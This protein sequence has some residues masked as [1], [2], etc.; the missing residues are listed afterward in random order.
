MSSMVFLSLD[1]T[2]EAALVYRVEKLL[3]LCIIVSFGG[4]LKDPD[5]LFLALNLFRHLTHS[6]FISHH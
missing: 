4:H 2:L 1:V 5:Q 6:I 3:L